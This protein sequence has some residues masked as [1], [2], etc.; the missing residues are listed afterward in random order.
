[1]F[2]A[3]PGLRILCSPDPEALLARAAAPYVRAGRPAA[4]PM[5]AV[6]HAH[7]RDEITER[8]ARAGCVG[9]LGEP[10][11]VFRELPGRIAQD[12][13]PLSARERHVLLMRLMR[14][15]R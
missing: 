3:M 10:L 13:A 5:L 1:M 9:W 12:H 8:A 7:L 14:E 15:H 6:R 2:G 4:L 11:L